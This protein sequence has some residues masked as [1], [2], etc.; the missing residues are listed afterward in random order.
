MKISNVKCFLPS[1]RTPI[2]KVEA[3]NGCFGWGEAGPSAWQRGFMF[4]ATLRHFSAFLIGKD[5]RRLGALWEQMYRGGAMEGGRIVAAT[6]SALDV[7]LHD[8]VARSLNVPVYQLL[9]GMQ[10]DSIPCF[11]PVADEVVPDWVSKGWQALRLSMSMGK[12]KG[13]WEPRE[14]IEL[15]A[16]RMIAVRESVG[17]GPAL[18]VDYHHA[19]S[20]AEAASFCQCLP[21]GTLDYIEDPIREATPGAYAALR[22]MTDIPFAVGEV[23]TS[24]WEWRPYIEQDLVQLARI[25]IGNVGGL[26]ESMKV[27]G[28]CET[29]Y[30]DMMPHLAISPLST[31]AIIH[32]LAALPNVAWMED[33]NRNRDATFKPRDPDMYPRQ[34]TPEGPRYPVTDDPG[35]GVEINE[36]AIAEA[37]VEEHL[38]AGEQKRQHRRDGAPLY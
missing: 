35:L 28:W 24:K 37:S 34:P 11:C 9:G 27:A 14:S 25:D 20:V 36:E 5:P 26:T 1:P 17:P 10:R 16:P 7:A 15:A 4:E 19:F 13:I 31:A 38:A 21:P 3:D 23:F 32:Y 29:H 33:R 2:V 18:G 6:V 22:R 30:V 12:D 8:L